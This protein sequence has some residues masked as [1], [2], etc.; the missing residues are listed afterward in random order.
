MPRVDVE[1]LLAEDAERESSGVPAPARF[2]KDIQVALHSGQQRHMGDPQRRLPPVAPSHFLA[3]RPQP[4]P[5]SREVRPARRRRVLGPRSRR[6]LGSRALHS[7]KSQ[8]SR[9]SVDRR[10]SSATNWSPNSHCSERDSRRI[11]KSRPSTTATASSARTTRSRR[12]KRGS[13]ATSTSS[14]LLQGDPWRDQI[15]SVALITISGILRLCTGQM[16]NNT[17]EDEITPYL[18]TAQHCIH[19]GKRGTVGGRLLELTKA[20]PVAMSFWAAALSENQSGSTLDR[21]V[22]V[23]KR[24]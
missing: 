23:T 6:I 12:A 19:C 7:R 24:L 4:E 9:R 18:L 8:R 15:R 1:A 16:L 14:A 17:A 3:R 20:R 2:A 11:S 22:R 10:S 13:T 5:W 21:L